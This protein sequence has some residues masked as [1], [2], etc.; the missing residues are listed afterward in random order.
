MVSVVVVS[1]G[2][3]VRA[4]F[5][6]VPRGNLLCSVMRRLPRGRRDVGEDPDGCVLLA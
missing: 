6:F 4:L 5:L 1:I 2:G 3:R